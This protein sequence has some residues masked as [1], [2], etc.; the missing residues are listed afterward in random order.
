MV[1][2]STYFSSLLWHRNSSVITVYQL[3]FHSTCGLMYWAVST[4]VTFI[5]FVTLNSIYF[6]LQ[7]FQIS[8]GILSPRWCTDTPLFHQTMMPR[9][10][11]VI[12]HSMKPLFVSTEIPRIAR[13]MGPTWGPSG[14]DRTQVGH[15]LAPWTLLSGSPWCQIGA[16]AG[17][18][19][20]GYIK[21]QTETTLTRCV[22]NA[23]I[24]LLVDQYAC[25]YVGTRLISRN[26]FCVSRTWSC[27]FINMLSYMVTTSTNDNSICTHSSF[28][29][30]DNLCDKCELNVGL[31]Q[32]SVV[33]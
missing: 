20:G 30:F 15:M 21:V 33:P 12:L 3:F 7:A 32:I 27:L 5:V 23:Q 31:S 11:Y 28:R 29:C 10:R 4:M 22:H 24:N 6:E 17:R 2:Y 18:G 25:L 16:V 13:F 26:Y 1:L 8:F 19:R 14:A 9:S